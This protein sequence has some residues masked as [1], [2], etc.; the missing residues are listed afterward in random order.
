MEQRIWTFPEKTK[1]FLLLFLLTGWFPATGRFDACLQ[2]QQQ[3]FAGC[4]S[5]TVT[6][7]GCSRNCSVG[8]ASVDACGPTPPVLSQRLLGD[9]NTNTVS[10]RIQSVKCE[11]V[12]ERCQP[13]AW[14]C[15]RCRLFWV[16]IFSK[17]EVR[18]A[19]S[20]EKQLQQL[21]KRRVFSSKETKVL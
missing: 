16:C 9:V 10:L 1:N 15:E 4:F 17:Q 11:R 2:Q 13:A 19:K 8:H 3:P 20:K 7:Q 14:R 6:S 21:R 5:Q 18:Q 12:C